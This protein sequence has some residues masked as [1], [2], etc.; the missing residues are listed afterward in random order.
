MSLPVSGTTN[1]AESNTPPASP[2]LVKLREA[3]NAAPA[4]QPARQPAPKPA[5][6]SPEA[7]RKGD[8]A[9]AI[10]PPVPESIEETGIPQSIIEHLILKYLYFRGDML[11]REIATSTMGLKF[12]VIEEMLETLKRQY[13]VGVKKSL[14]MGNSSGVFA[15]TE[16]GR[17]LT[18]EYLENNLYAGPAPVPLY[19]YVEVV[20]RQ[21]LR[22]NW[23]N[24]STLKEAFRHLV[25]DQDILSQIGPAVN[26]N[27]SFLIYGQPGNGK[28]RR[29]RRLCSASKIPSPSTCRMPLKCQGNIIQLLRSDSITRKFRISRRDGVFRCHLAATPLRPGAGSSAAVLSSSLAASWAWKRST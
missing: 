16:T 29:W 3:L 20:K 13:Y 11:G 14:G 26:A 22:A 4:N 6:P 5:P 1:P 28:T 27:K 21:K 7:A 23:L 17:S 10:T 15:L 18:R 9:D 8:I 24:P 12:S 19:Q 2:Q 25:V